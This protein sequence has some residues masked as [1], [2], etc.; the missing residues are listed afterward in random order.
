MWLSRSVSQPAV[1]KVDH[2][3]GFEKPTHAQQTAM[4]HI[5]QEIGFG[6]RVA[7]EN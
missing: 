1:D 6:V 2:S 5:R 7:L 4:P 3:S